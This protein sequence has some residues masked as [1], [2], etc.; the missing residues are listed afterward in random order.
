MVWPFSLR[1]AADQNLDR[2]GF[3]L[4]WVELILVWWSG[5]F[6]GVFADFVVQRGGKSW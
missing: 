5:Y 3:C 6:T 1:E 2:G 4:F